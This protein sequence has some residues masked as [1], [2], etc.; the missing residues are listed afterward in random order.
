MFALAGLCLACALEQQLVPVG[1]SPID[2]GKYEATYHWTESV[3]RLPDIELFVVTLA[4]PCS[5][6]IDDGVTPDVV[7]SFVLAN[8]EA[9]D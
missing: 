7:H 6:I 4:F 5:H 8:A 1:V 9:F 2:Y 3:C